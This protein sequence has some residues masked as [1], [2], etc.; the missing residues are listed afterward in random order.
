MTGPQQ[1]Q[2]PPVESTAG[3][4]PPAVGTTEFFSK[5]T[6]TEYRE[7]KEEQERLENEKLMKRFPGWGREKERRVSKDEP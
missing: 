2:S 5:M 3:V 7:Y 1:P 4:A 6:P